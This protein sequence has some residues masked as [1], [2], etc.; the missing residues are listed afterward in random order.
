M[1]RP[2]VLASASP[3]RR[4]LLEQ[5]GLEFTIVV[6]DVVESDCDWASP[7][8]LVTQLAHHKA[9]RVAS[10]QSKEAVII[11]ADTVV[12]VDGQV[13]GKP[14]HEA[15]AIA[16]LRCLRGREHQVYTGVAVVDSLN[17][18]EAQAYEMTRVFMR[19]YGD[20]EIERYVRSG[21]PRDKAGAYAIQGLGALLV[22]G[23]EGCY[24]NVVGLPVARLGQ[25]LQTIGIPV[26]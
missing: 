9:R 11:G 25:M 21:E 14:A 22:A 2:I 18:Q 20:D 3:R 8:E 26:L 10:S 12:V 4:E 1:P 23:I 19:R 5:I 16:M 24:T 15:E 7:I 13:L 17:E 6:S